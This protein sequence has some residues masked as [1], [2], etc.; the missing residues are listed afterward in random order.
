LQPAIQKAD[1]T[2]NNKNA[3]QHLFINIFILLPLSTDIQNSSFLASSTLSIATPAAEET[4]QQTTGDSCSQDK[5]FP[6]HPGLL[7]GSAWM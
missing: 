7:S 6:K 4:E 5:G 2:S 3:T 1:I